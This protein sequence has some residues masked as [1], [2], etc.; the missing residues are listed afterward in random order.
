MQL[1]WNHHDLYSSFGYWAYVVLHIWHWQIFGKLQL[2]IKATTEASCR[3]DKIIAYLVVWSY[4]LHQ[5]N[6]KSGKT[7]S[8]KPNIKSNTFHLA[9]VISSFEQQRSLLLSLPEGARSMLRVGIYAQLLSSFGL[10][11]LKFSKQSSLFRH[12]F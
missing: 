1:S 9:F 12:T 6:S 4:F 3:K 8:N 11:G 10:L 5:I 7:W 2:K